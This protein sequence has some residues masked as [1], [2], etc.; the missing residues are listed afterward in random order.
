M[1]LTWGRWSAEIRGDEVADVCYD[2]VY[3]LR[4]V[5]AVVRDRDWNTVPVRVLSQNLAEDSGLAL[6]LQLLYED[7]EIT[8]AA[9]LR[10]RLRDNALMLQFDGRA[11]V[12]LERNRIGLVVLHPASDA[13]TAVS[14][15]HT[16]G[17]L[18]TASWPTEISPHQPFRDVSGFEWDKDGVRATLTLAGD[19]FET[20]DQRNWTDASFKTY[21]TPLS[22]PFPVTVAK[23]SGCQQRLLLRVTGSAKIPSSHSK[24]PSRDAVTI[25]SNVVGPLPPIS[26]GACLFPSP[27]TQWQG[28]AHFESVLAELTGASEFWP[29]TLE[30]AGEQA[31]AIGVPLD[32]R[33]VADDPALIGDGVRLL[34][35]VPVIR[36]GTFDTRTHMTTSEHWQALRDAAHRHDFT[37]QLVGG[38]RAHF[39][40]L[41]RNIHQIPD[42]LP[43]LTFSITPQMHAIE[44]P[45]IIDSLPMQR[46]V[47][48]NAMRLGSG[49]PV[50][51]GPITLARRFNAVATSGLSGPVR[52]A[53]RAVDALQHSEFAGA[54]TVGSVAQLTAAHVA[55]LCYFETLAPRGIMTEDGDLTP[56]GRVLTRLAEL[57]GS[58][59]LEAVG[60]DHLAILAVRT[61]SGQTQLIL[62]NLT[63]RH[64]TIVIA[65]L[66]K[67]PSGVDVAPWSVVESVL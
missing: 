61:P 12:D 59:V 57:R 48:E 1:R 7:E 39:T 45:H 47:A 27:P 65:H 23:A 36:L 50:L 18:T 21:S 3:L 38:T 33:L 46:V 43:V 2:G 49:R 66:D 34:H 62:G 44:I 29:Q 42:E 53:S 25:T 11:L 5:R 67:Q 32:V 22:L 15:R 60:P 56:A 13:G 16:D 14:V 24:R 4:A 52:D 26:M 51:V 6:R 19:T 54:W 40:E 31:K 10:L 30:L 64:R 63:P 28:A 41:N 37:G 35:R 17:T 55:G 8:Y 9:T 20:E 58:P